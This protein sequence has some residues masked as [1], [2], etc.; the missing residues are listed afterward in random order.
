MGT[1]TLKKQNTPGLPASNQLR[2]F[3]DISDNILKTIDSLG[4]VQPSG[5]GTASQLATAGA[6]VDVSAATPPVAGQ[7]LTSVTPT[8][9][10]WANPGLTPTSLKTSTYSAVVGDL[11]RADCSGG[12]FSI[13]LPNSHTAGNQIGIKVYLAGANAVTVTNPGGDTIDGSPVLVL[14]G[15]Y[16]WAILMSDGA[17][18]ME[19]S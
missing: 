14:S 3:V 16:T 12:S 1:I 17:N 4:N 5:V 2:L 7:V 8:T 10:R 13:N 15:N 19:I 11:V 6:P 18:W 9:S